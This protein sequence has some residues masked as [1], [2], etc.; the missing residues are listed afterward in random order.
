MYFIFYGRDGGD[1]VEGGAQFKYLG[2]PLVQT[3]DDW[4]AVQ[5]NFKRERKV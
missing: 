4:P 3:D 2:C 5:R 1:M